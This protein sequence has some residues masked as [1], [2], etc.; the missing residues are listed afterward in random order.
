M[1]SLALRRLALVRPAGVRQMS[2]HT[3]EE[4]IAETSKWKKI[5]YG[6]LPIVGLVGVYVGYDHIKHHSHWEQVDYPYIGRRLKPMPWTLFGGSA[7]A[8]FDYNCAAKEKAAKAALAA[9]E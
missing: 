5:S 2:G 6:F 7:C 4:A 9:E 1:Q 8:L 3:V